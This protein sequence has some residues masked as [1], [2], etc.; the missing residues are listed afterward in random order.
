MLRARQPGK[1][2]FQIHPAAVTRLFQLH[3]ED[4]FDDNGAS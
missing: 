3:I 4:L 1:L 2:G